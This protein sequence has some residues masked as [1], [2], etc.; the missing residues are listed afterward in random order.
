LILLLNALTQPCNAEPY[1]VDSV[2]ANV[3]LV[4]VQH[5]IMATQR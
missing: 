5:H 2:N 1:R 3:Q 4:P